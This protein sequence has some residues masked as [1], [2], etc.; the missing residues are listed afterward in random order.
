MMWYLCTYWSDFSE[1]SNHC[2]SGHCCKVFKVIVQGHRTTVME[3]LWTHCLQFTRFEQTL[4][5]KYCTQEMNLD[6]SSWSVERTWTK[7]IR[8]SRWWVQRS[9]SQKHLQVEQGCRFLIF[10]CNSDSGVRKF[11]TPHSW[12]QP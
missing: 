1:V 4:I 11:I 10:L 5:Q 6:N 3:I 8:F 2:V 7:L 12:L 9:R